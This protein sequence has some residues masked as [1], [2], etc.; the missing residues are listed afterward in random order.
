MVRWWLGV[1]GTWLMVASPAGAEPVRLEGPG[2]PLVLEH[3]AVEATVQFGLAVVDVRQ[4]FHNPFDQVIDATYTFPL[5]TGAAVRA[6][7]LRCGDRELVARVTE[8]DAARA[9]YA[10]AQRE[11]RRAALTEQERPNLFTQ[12]VARIC[13]GETVEVELQYVE[14]LTPEDEAWSITFPTTVGPYFAPTDL[15]LAHT[16]APLRRSLDVMVVIDEGLPL[17]WLWSDSHALV[18][19][20]SPDGTVVTLAEVERPNQDVHLRWSLASP[21]PVAAAVMARRPG[22]DEAYVAVRIEPPRLRDIDPDDIRPRELLFVLD[23]SC[24][25]AGEPWQAAVE[26]VEAA[27]YRMRSD[28]TFNLVKFSNAASTVFPSPQPVTKETLRTARAWLQAF[29]GG[30]TVMTE[31]IVRSLTMPGDPGALRTVLL[32]TDGYIGND[33]E[34][35]DRVRD[36]LSGNDRIFALGIGSSPNRGLLDELAHHGRGDALYQLPQRPILKTVDAFVTR[37]DTPVITDVEVDFGP[38][39]VT[40]IVP[41]VLPDLFAGQSVQVVGRV[42]RLVPTTVTVRGWHGQRPVRYTV[43]L[44]PAEV[45]T[46]EAVPALWAREAIREVERDLSLGDGAKK[47]EIVPIAL[48]HHLVSRF[49]SLVATDQDPTGCDG[50]GRWASDWTFGAEPVEVP[51]MVPAGMAGGLGTR[52]SGLGGGGSAQGLGGLGAPRRRSNASGFGKGGGN[53]CVK[54]G[55]GRSHTGSPIILGALDRSQID[56]VIRRE[57]NKLK[58]C[59]QRA[60]TKDRTLTGKVAV[61][62]TIIGDGTV[63]DADIKS[64]TMNHEG[65]EQCLVEQ[66]RR[67]TFPAPAGHTHVIVSYPFLFAPR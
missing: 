64:T 23:S 62:F 61:R 38:L 35:F 31:G 52:G 9:A 7:T 48:D 19:E 17:R 14:R 55:G 51:S 27:L 47:A 57:M 36:N 41:S 1:L 67:L 3:V 32:L 18:T 33:R 42:D 11:G 58:Y 39:D 28:D 15:D 5:S 59:Y 43:V 10:Q 12:Q 26:T 34:V 30:G 16:T 49:T 45:S 63:S 46:H 66:V 50:L 4:T 2:G 44:D 8:R 56:R 6:M 40:D 22:D 24:S 29:E 25:M 54:G 53:C 21:E 65:V 60:L 13:P 20:D 37:I